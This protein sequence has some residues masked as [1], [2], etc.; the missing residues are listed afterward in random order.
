[1]Q[2]GT[3]PVAKLVISFALA[4]ITSSVAMWYWCFGKGRPLQSHQSLAWL[5]ANIL[6]MATISA[7]VGVYLPVSSSWSWLQS[8]ALPAT[9]AGSKSLEHVQDPT[10]KTGNN[11]VAQLFAAVVDIA[12]WCVAPLRALLHRRMR[13]DM[14]EWVEIVDGARYSY[15]EWDWPHLQTRAEQLYNSLSLYMA[16]EPSN[17]GALDG[18]Y[19]LTLQETWHASRI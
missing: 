19:A 6:A 4:L 18:K 9:L 15:D 12:S 5:L 16:D 10:S 8:A 2:Y 17:L 3:V 14:V 7:A 1:M 11:A 13:R